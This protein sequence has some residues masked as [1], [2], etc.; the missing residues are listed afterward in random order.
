MI[1][2][3][4]RFHD[5]RKS[6][7]LRIW[8]F[9]EDLWVTFRYEKRVEI[10]LGEIDKALEEIVFKVRRR[11]LRTALKTTNELLRKHFLEREAE[12][13]VQDAARAEG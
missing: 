11:Y 4:I 5:W 13:V 6:T 10:D 7:S 8:A 1:S 2:V 12:I 3:R 9:G